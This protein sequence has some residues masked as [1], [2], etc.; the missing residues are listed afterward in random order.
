MIAVVQLRGLAP[1]DPETLTVAQTPHRTVSVDCSW[2]L[3]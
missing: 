2:R 3:R 1:L